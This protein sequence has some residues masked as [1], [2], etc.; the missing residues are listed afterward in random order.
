MLRSTTGVA[1]L[2]L[3]FGV[4]GTC[5][6]PVMGNSTAVA[7]SST[8]QSCL[9]PGSW[10]H[11]DH[12]RAVAVSAA[13]ALR[14][15]AAQD[16]VLLGE[17][18]TSAD[19]HRWQLQ[20]LAALHLLHPHMA[21]GFESF[22]RRLQPIL[23]K[24]VAGELDADEFLKQTDWQKIWGYSAEFYMPMFE[25]ARMNHLPMIALNVDKAL[26]EAVAKQGWDAIPASMKEGLSRPA[27]PP[28]VYVDKLFDIYKQHAMAGAGS[29]GMTQSNPNF[30]RFV[31]AQSTWDRAMAEAL[32]QR[33]SSGQNG[34]RLLAVG[35]MGAGHVSGGN[36]IPHQLHDL[37]INRIAKLLPVNVSPDCK[38]F[39]ADYADAVFA[40]PDHFM[41]QARLGAQLE[42][43]Q[44]EIR[45]VAVEPGSVAQLAG[46]QPG[47]S[48][49]MAGGSF[50]KG[51]DE[52]LDTIR[53]A[54][55]GSWLPVK[56]ERG[57]HEQLHDVVLKFPSRR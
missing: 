15:A 47:D 30:R 38:P 29:A 33:A 1:S 7:R 18:H 52:L 49:V 54:P 23:D 39:D 5:S 19:D 21:I 35:I 50:V 40:L 16:V 42:D 55:P 36:G 12:G 44:G 53:D 45:I 4:A 31:E 34:Q 11:L 25:F 46:L 26:P 8:T 6:T 9:V 13:D 27:A 22:P 51:M 20:T 56:V 48:F 28:Q 10:H 43:R 32:A 41:K 37:G 57:E 2:I 3:L 14:D 24:W 17:Y